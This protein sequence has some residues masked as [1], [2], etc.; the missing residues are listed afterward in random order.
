MYAVAMDY[1]QKYAPVVAE[2]LA[3]S[4]ATITQSQL[5]P[6]VNF[7]ALSWLERMWAEYYIYM[8]NPIIATGVMS[9]LLHEVRDC[10]TY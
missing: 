7:A 6:G 8:G 5:Y 1:L 4:N 2:Q 3:I 10:R 9:F